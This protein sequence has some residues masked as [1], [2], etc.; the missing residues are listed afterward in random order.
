[1]NTKKALPLLGALLLGILL[2][3]VRL[4]THPLGLNNYGYDYG[5]Y[6][7]AVQHTDLNSP[8][9]FLGQ[10]NDYGNHLHVI[11]NII[12]LPQIQSLEI[13]FFVFQFLSVALIFLYIRKK[14]Y[15]AGA[16]AGLWF[17]FSVAQTQVHTMFLWKTSYGVLLLILAFLFLEYKKYYHAAISSLLL[18]ITHK[19]TLLAGGISTLIYSLIGNLV[20][21]PRNWRPAIGAIVSLAVVVYIL[22][23]WGDYQILKSS[24]TR[25]GIFMEIKTYLMFS[26]YLLPLAGYYLYDSIKQKRVTLWISLAVTAIIWL[27]LG[28]PFSQRMI[29]YLDISLIVL[30]GLGAANLFQRVKKPYLKS[31]LFVVILFVSVLQYPI[32]A[33]RIKPQITEAQIEEIKNFSIQNQGAFVLSLGA[34]DAP[35]LLANLSGNV[36][37]GAPGLFED[38]Q[39]E[40]QWKNMWLNPE[41]EKFYRAFPRPLFIY[42]RDR[43]IYR[44]PWRCLEK[45]SEHFYRYI[46]N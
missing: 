3:A 36:R 33:G 14:S 10:V 42:Q 24:Q 34:K 2:V 43:I 27:V 29:V 8:L 23:G 13:L 38:F 1:M 15:W 40:Y 41:N 22:G 26:W 39:T 45:Y 16:L 37:L 30:A 35:W 17:T 28:L 9:Y 12:R 21:K 7:Y 19:T 46:C 44:Q 31:G 4:A 11:L 32:W 20:Y 18:I 6:S 5:F 25:D